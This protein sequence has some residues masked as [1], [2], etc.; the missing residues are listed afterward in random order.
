M[1]LD[2]KVGENVQGKVIE[3]L[4]GDELLISL[5]GTLIRV[6]NKTKRRFA[7]G[8]PVTLNVRAINPLRFQ[9][10]EERAEQ[11]RRGHLNVNI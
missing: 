1:K 5:S 9:L 8:D 11:R 6:A 10:V 7:T 2:A 4:L 3:L